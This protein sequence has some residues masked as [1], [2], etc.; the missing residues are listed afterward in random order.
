MVIHQNNYEQYV[1]DYVEGNLS[2]EQKIAMEQFLQEHPEQSEEIENLFAYQLEPKH[3]V[4]NKKELLYKEEKQ[5]NP[6]IQWMIAAASMAILL[7]VGFQFMNTNHTTT[8]FV[9]EQSA[10]VQTTEQENNTVGQA[11]VLDKAITTTEPVFQQ[12]KS[13]EVESVSSTTKQGKS[14]SLE[15]VNQQQPI[16]MQA[17]RIKEVE[18]ISI[19]KPN[20]PQTTQKIVPKIATIH[21]AQTV[22][23]VSIE[24][25]I[26]QVQIPKSKLLEK[27]PTK[28]DAIVAK[29]DET[30]RKGILQTVFGIN[31]EQEK[32]IKAVI[33]PKSLVLSKP[34]ADDFVPHAYRTSQTIRN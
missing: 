25:P 32:S 8:E 30:N 6:A 21:T 31:S 19:P 3:I 28:N 34:E 7:V 10:P 17:Q 33:L 14:N 16:E 11:P 23:N 24:L 15:E 18:P 22:T 2:T 5:Q 1:L 29:E 12:V 4:F 20:L 27:V 26:E 13:T 9:S